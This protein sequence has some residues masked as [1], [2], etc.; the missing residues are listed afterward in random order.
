MPDSM[1][2]A[3]MNHGGEQSVPQRAIVAF[4]CIFL[5]AATLYTY[6][7]VQSFE[8]V[9][10]DDPLYIL[11]NSVVKDGLTAQGLAWAF[12]SFSAANW[13]PLT[14]I[15]HMADVEV[16]RFNPAGH[17]WTGVVIHAAN[18]VLL[19]LVLRAMTQ[20]TWPS[21]L[22][23]ALFALHPLHVESVAWISER[24]DVLSTFFWFAAMGAYLGYTRKP[25][26]GRYGLVLLL[27]SL[28]LLS[29]PMLVTFPFFLM[30]IDYWPLNRYIDTRTILDRCWLAQNLPS[31]QAIFS[32][33]R[34]KD[35][36]DP[37]VGHLQRLNAAGPE[38]R[39]GLYLD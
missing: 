19:F 24:K 7:D 13:H 3:T 29:K 37:A 5:A 1:P 25:D 33:D 34:R 10:Y 36:H 31:W 26:L 38:G 22:V 32:S 35:S 21:A 6:W 15:S 8:F 27:F 14:W 20:C 12:N 18:G 28:G 9:L 17:H 16:F 4:I 30:L 2:V 39:G 23:S 11:N